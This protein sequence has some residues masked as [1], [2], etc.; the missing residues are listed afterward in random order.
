MRGLKY[1]FAGIVI[2]IISLFSTQAQVL[3]PVKW[4]YEVRDLGNGE[5]ELIF[6]AAIDDGWHLYSQFIEDGG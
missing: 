3:E 1:F 5:Y 6:K 2:A 4:T